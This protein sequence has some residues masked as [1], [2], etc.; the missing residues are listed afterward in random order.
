M[1]CILFY[2]PAYRR[3]ASRIADLPGIEPV[4]MQKD[5]RILLDGK[6]VTAEDANAEIG[7]ANSDLFAGPVRE[8]M[9][10]LLKT[11][12]LRWLQSGAAGFDNPVFAQ[13]VSKGARL[14]TSHV[15]AVGMAEYTLATVLD[16]LQR[17]PERRAEQAAHRWTRLQFKEVMHSRWLIVG[18]GAIGQEIARRAKA[19]GAHITGIRR[20]QAPHE[21]ADAIAPQEKILDLLPDADVVVLCV[22]LS[23]QTESLANARFFAAMKADA[24]LVNIGR[25]GLVDEDALLA[26]LD[27]GKPAHAILD[28]FRTEPLPAESKFWSHPRVTVTPHASPIGSGLTARGDDLF[29]ENLHRYM[30]GK[31]L[32]DEADPKDVMGG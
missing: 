13:I 12:K 20:N 8:Y 15:Q 28:V 26:A 11:P 24:V 14:T 6:E 22:P 4:L 5:G 10:A 19:F 31:P 3:I 18:F 29:V 25:G 32:R 7:W 2:E 21:L 17:G 16:H 23:K 30:S 27:A 9:I 1:P